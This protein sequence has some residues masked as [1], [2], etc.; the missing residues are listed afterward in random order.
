MPALTQSGPA[1]GVKPV[2]N[3]LRDF[4]GH[5]RS[6]TEKASVDADGNPVPWI[7]YPA[8]MFF[9]QLDLRSWRIF[10]Y[11]SGNSTLYWASRVQEIASVESSRDYYESLLPTLPPNASLS[12]AAG[13]EYAQSSRA[14]APYDM[15]V[16]DGRWRFDSSTEAL[17]NISKDGVIVLDNSERFPIVCKNI[18]DA[19]FIQVDFSGY[20]PINWFT[21]TTSVFLSRT[22]KL[23][24]A[25]P[26]RPRATPGHVDAYEQ[27]PE[28]FADQNRPG[29]SG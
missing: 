21:W 26:H 14:G 5:G 6:V 24:P 17:K 7:T 19:G 9:E 18:T 16:I 29:S 27:R 23:P 11:G 22:V 15:I 1:S 12:F 28:F 8:I 13:K 10:E 20:G 2:L 4:Y 3:H 25:M